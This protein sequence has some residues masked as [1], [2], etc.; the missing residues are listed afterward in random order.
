[1][2]GFAALTLSIVAI[3]LL[4]AVPAAAADTSPPQLVDIQLSSSSFTVTGFAYAAIQLRLHLTDDTGVVRADS[5]S[6]LGLPGSP[7]VELTPS[8]VV[9][10]QVHSLDADVFTLTSGTPQD[11]WWTTTLRMTA[12]YD[13]NWTVSEV[14]ATDGSGNA[15][16]VDPRN[17][18]INAT[19]HVKGVDIP[20]LSMRQTPDPEIGDRN[21]ITFTGHVTDLDTGQ[22]LRA[23]VHMGFDAGCTTFPYGGASSVTSAADGSWRLTFPSWQPNA[24]CAS[25]YNLS[26]VPDPVHPGSMTTVQIFYVNIPVAPHYRWPV[27]ASLATHSIKLGQSTTV[28]GSTGAL[29]ERVYLQRMVSGSWHTV[30]S[31]VVRSSGRFTLVAEPPSRGYHHYRVLLL[32][33]Y[34]GE[35]AS[36]SSVLYLTV[37]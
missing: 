34:P 15:L 37:T 2:R 35:Q 33:W 18:G 6:S 9:K 3:V 8:F 13:G 11:G 7:Y 30:G 16:N 27:G 19:M 31:T 28:N 1:M 21:S 26:R 22:P 36:S 29:G 5:N 20:H 17:Q 23:S 10:G 4:P 32:P 25:I 14:R 12:G 24:G